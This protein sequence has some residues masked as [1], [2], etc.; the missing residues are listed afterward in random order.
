MVLWSVCFFSI[1]MIERR[2]M[3]F[4]NFWQDWLVAAGG[5]ATCLIVGRLFASPFGAHVDT[6]LLMQIIV[7]ALLYPVDRQLRRLARRAAGTPHEPADAV[8]QAEGQQ[9]YSFSRRAMALG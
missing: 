1:D 4:R 2:I 8:R 5:I 7:S 6:V 3:M 9:T